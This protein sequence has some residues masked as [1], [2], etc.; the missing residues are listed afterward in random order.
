M[1]KRSQTTG[2]PKE[3]PAP[4]GPP[5]TDPEASGERA[6]IRI[7]REHETRHERDSRIQRWVIIGTGLAIAAVVL[8]LVVT[9]VMDQLVVPNQV[10][11]TVDGQNITVAQFQK[12]VRIERFLR[13]E[14]IVNIIQTYLQFGYTEQQILQQLQSAPP[15]SDWV[16]QLQVPDQMG[17]AVIDQMIED[18]LIR[19]AARERGITVSQAQ[20]DDRINEF[21]GYNPSEFEA[22]PEATGEP[23]AT[24]TPTITPTPYVSPTPSPT[25]T[26]TPTP[27]FTATPS[28]TPLPSLAP[29]AT[30]NATERANTF[31]TQRSDYFRQIR[32]A[33][34][35][36]DGDINEYFEVLALRKAL[37]DSVTTDL[38]Q[39]GMFADVRHILVAT[40]AE[41]QDIIA[42]LNAG[43][44]FSALAR[45][46]STDTGSGARG[47]EL[48]WA[49]VTQYVTEFADAV[50]AAEL[51]AIVGPVKSEFG[52]HIIQVRAR[53]DRELDES[54]LDNAKA[55]T[56]S[57]WLTD[58]KETKQAVT[59]T[60]PTW[61]SH[62]PTDP[63]SIFG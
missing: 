16:Q 5:G 58:Y 46:V 63:A 10:V 53:E 21:F 61:T 49:P 39:Q 22:A 7:Q 15:Y 30:P 47:G 12:R 11:A 20:I 23:S 35:L 40:E 6:R 37:E 14:Q 62:V 38:T 31:Q 27:E 1:T 13:N 59:Q 33:T 54:Q 34:G 18:Q 57:G 9:F 32:L 43:E 48:G 25:P 56:F 8:L 26:L 52:Y 55:S 44:S 24:P 2:L 60:F 45:A 29:S 41:A 19:N 50:R 3:S 4:K 42:A 28:L 51:G 36:S 17:L